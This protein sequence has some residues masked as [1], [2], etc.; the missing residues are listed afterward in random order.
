MPHQCIR[1]SKIYPDAS[2]ELLE[3]CEC[4]S[5]FFFFIRQED[6]ESFEKN[7]IPNLD[8]SEVKEIEKEVKDIIG[9]EELD[10]TKPVVLDLESVWVK[11]PG[12][13]DID[14][15]KILSKK[16]LVYKIEEGK[17]IIDLAS[18]FQLSKKNEQKTGD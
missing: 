4:G 5:K 8:S 17:Y 11:K 18:T 1:C 12:K 10:G 14:L 2:K 13:F 3:G 16:S 7:V 6:L 15:V 9:T